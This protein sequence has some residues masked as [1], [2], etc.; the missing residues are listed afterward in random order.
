MST[1]NPSPLPSEDGDQH[2][3]SPTV[4]AP[5]SS[6]VQPGAKKSQ[7][8]HTKRLAKQ[9]QRESGLTYQQ[10]LT[11]VQ[12]QRALGLPVESLEPHNV[13]ALVAAW[14]REGL[15]GKEDFEFWETWFEDLPLN[16][17]GTWTVDGVDTPWVGGP[18]GAGSLWLTPRV[19]AT[20]AEQGLRVAVP[21][22][23]TAVTR[24]LC[25]AHV[26]VS[27][28][29]LIL[30]GVRFFVAGRAASAEEEAAAR[31]L[32]S[33][34]MVQIDLD[35][36]YMSV[37]TFPLSVPWADLL[38]AS[39]ETM[40]PD[41]VDGFVDIEETACAQ[42]LA[43]ADDPAATYPEHLAGSSAQPPASH[44]RRSGRAAGL[45]PYPGVCIDDALVNLGGPGIE[46]D[47][48]R[49]G[50]VAVT[51]PRMHTRDLWWTLLLHLRAHPGAYL[52][53]V[54]DVHERDVDPLRYLGLPVA[55]TVA[56]A[57]TLLAGLISPSWK[58]DSNGSPRHPVGQPRTV[59][60][61]RDF[62][63]LLT[64]PFGSRLAEVLAL[65]P[66]HT[67]IQLLIESH[68]DFDRL[69]ES[70]RGQVSTVLRPPSPNSRSGPGLISFEAAG[71]SEVFRGYAAKRA[72]TR[73][74]DAPSHPTR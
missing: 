60:A 68:L 58:A 61:V 10:A 74:V 55:T 47:L 21:E 69:P 57:E 49:A 65:D 73:Q 64:S 33:A 30:D 28:G 26:V 41:A 72:L 2:R 20:I 52:T 59:V 18:N 40:P 5:A 27:H 62:D 16:G 39:L 71:H 36:G 35:A 4:S 37:G 3:P 53:Q 15:A 22:L 29:E 7:S 44:T 12:H 13:E 54:I 6:P 11:E 56:C 45:L 25:S 32:L 50:H 9:L 14:L 42:R 8:T 70:L 1:T 34:R 23:F 43:V 67:G 48:P 66:H 24:G 46:M 19:M 38:D 31:S 63:S 51:G 17:P